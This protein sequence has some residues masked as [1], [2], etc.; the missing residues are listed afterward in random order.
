MEQKVKLKSK[1]TVNSSKLK[2]YDYLIVGSGLYG[3]TFNYLA[4]K[5]GKSTLIVEKRDVVGGNLYC[6]K[7]E[8]IYVH[9][10][11]PHIFHTDNIRVWNFVNNIT[12]FNP[13]MLQ[14]MSRV[15]DKL[16]SLPFNMYTFNQLWGV[17]T[18]EEAK[19]RINKDKYTGVV[20]NLEEQAL[21]LVGRDIYEKLIKGYTEKQWGRDCRNLPSFII[22][23]LPTRFTFNGNYFNDRYQGIPEGCYNAMIDKL[24]E[25]TEVITGVDY[26]TNR[27][28]YEKIADKIVYTG[29]IDEYFG[30]KY[31]KLQYRTV[32]WDTEIIEV[33]NYQGTAVINQPDKNVEYTRIIE[34]KHF[35]PYN[36]RIHQLNKTVIS[37]E[38][39]EEWDETKEGYYPIN[40]EKNNNLYKK[41]K[42][43]A[44][45]EKNVIFGGRLAEYKY[46]DMKDIIESVFNYWDKY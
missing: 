35:E 32:R 43:L 31:G 23:R 8:G 27:E 25:D 21:S 20:H 39:S 7:V 17:T 14:T 46:Y 6:E 45:K 33:A 19:A 5:K 38:Y 4:K 11:G 16:Y 30:Y 12:H 3:S 9:K 29:K 37:K 13:Y 44:D 22:K 28:M 34:H 24:L 15:G 36:E 40:D 26:N 18:P 42:E 41:Y 2:H 1:F 10:Y